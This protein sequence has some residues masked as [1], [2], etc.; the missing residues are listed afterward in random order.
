MKYSD[1]S[2]NKAIEIGTGHINNFQLESAEGT[3]RTKAKFRT[4]AISQRN[5]YVKKQIE[6]FSD[7]KLKLLDEIKNR[8]NSLMP[9]NNTSTFNSMESNVK[10]L[11]E[12]V[13]FNSCMSDSFKLGLDYYLAKL[14]NETSLEDFNSILNDFINKFN[15]YGIQL[16]I[17]DFK[18][19][20]F[21]EKYMLSFF[22]NSSF[23][24]LRNVFE[25]IY[26]KCP[27]IK[28]QM[29]MNLSFIISK[30]SNKLSNIV[31]KKIED[32]NS[33]LGTNKDDYLNK[34][35]N[36]RIELGTKESQDEFINTNLFL[37]GKYK[38]D[39]FLD[40]SPMKNKNYELFIEGAFD[41]FDSIV[42]D[43]YNSSLLDLYLTINELKKYYT[44]EFIIK[45][46]LQRYKNKDNVKNDV[47]NKKK[48]IDKAEKERIKYY[49]SYLKAS[50]IGIFAFKNE[51]KRNDAMLKINETVKNLNKLYEEYK[52]LTMTNNL[53]SLNES[54]TIYDL[55]MISLTSFTFIE[56]CFVNK[57]EFVGELSDIVSDYLRFI[58]NPINAFIR[59]VNVLI[60]FDIANIITEK[61]KILDLTI[62]DA[63]LSSD[64]IDATIDS[65]KTINL[66]Q[67]VDKS[68]ISFN[69]I[70]VLYDMNQIL[71]LYNDNHE[72][73]SI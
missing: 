17:D 54:C 6:E 70:K 73:D 67:N 20:M 52:D 51:A 46:L 48:E 69:D 28:L 8:Y 62:T 25:H 34:Y 33:E 7:L 30:Y 65:L 61:F 1:S 64:G 31:K 55:F 42:K 16:S 14:S 35:L 22:D 29:K 5:N 12:L 10:N 9:I 13:I 47:A 59:K 15:E 40:T 68:N 60:D 19:T 36:A 72:E 4:L 38:I 56:K 39:D 23:D 44:Y 18:Y 66:I 24:E 57:E 27:D 11:F 50:G 58:Y 49:H 32:K 37:D 3:K 71:N 53:N 43:R 63:M 45:D 2:I 41:G 21:T 26:F